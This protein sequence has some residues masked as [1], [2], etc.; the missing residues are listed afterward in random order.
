MIARAVVLL[1]KR[2]SWSL[3]VTAPPELRVRFGFSVHPL[4]M[5]DI[6][7]VV[8]VAHSLDPGSDMHALRHVVCE[9]SL[10][11]RHFWHPVPG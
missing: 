7:R 6:M 2:V 9:V 11:A 4:V 10:E 3:V 5:S 8:H 1:S